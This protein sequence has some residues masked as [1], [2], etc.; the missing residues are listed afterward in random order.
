MLVHEVGEGLNIIDFSECEA[1]QHRAKAA[2]EFFLGCC[3]QTA[4]GAPVKGI[5]RRQNFVLLSFGS[6]LFA[7]VKAGEFDEGLVGFGAA[8]AEEGFARPC[9]LHE[10]FSQKALVGVAEEVAA[11]GKLG[12]LVGY[13][14]KPSGMAMS[15]GCYGDAGSKVEVFPS[16][17]VPN[18]NPD[19]L[20]DG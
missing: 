2:S 8:V 5:F 14:L 7:A 20:I 9:A 17:I 18:G 13:F 16:C 3:G 1:V 19:A 4:H 11:V 12:C 10:F 15:E 6:R